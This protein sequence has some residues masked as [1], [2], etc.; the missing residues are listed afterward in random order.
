MKEGQKMIKVAV[1]GA[2]IAGLS[3]AIE[4]ERHGITPVIFE[5]NTGRAVPFPSPP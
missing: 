4:L 3:C 2:G 5:K 1:I